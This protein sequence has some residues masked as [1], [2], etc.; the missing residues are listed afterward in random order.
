VTVNE[1]ATIALPINVT[2]QDADDVVISII[3]SGVPTDAMLADA[4]VVNLTSARI[5]HD[6][7][8]VNRAWNLYCFSAQDCA[9]RSN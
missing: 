3:A 1:N 4:I 9:P 2:P 6:E 8:S 5:T 7:W